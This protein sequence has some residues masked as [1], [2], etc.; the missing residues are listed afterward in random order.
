MTNNKFGNLFAMFVVAQICIY[1]YLFPVPIGIQGCNGIGSHFLGALRS[2]IISIAIILAANWQS[3]NH[4]EEAMIQERRRRRIPGNPVDAFKELSYRIRNYRT[5]CF[6]STFDSAY[7]FNRLL[8]VTSTGRSSSQSVS[9]VHDPWICKSQ[10]CIY[11]VR[12]SSVNE[13]R[14][15]SI[16]MLHWLNIVPQWRRDTYAYK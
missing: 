14:R 10:V 8:M 11:V 3:Y 2:P 15:A 16:W 9:S 7:A 5:G 13:R 4:S 12:H 6:E 1:Y